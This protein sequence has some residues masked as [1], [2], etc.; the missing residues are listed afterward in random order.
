MPEL[1]FH[2]WE[3]IEQQQIDDDDDDEEQ[4]MDL[5]EDNLNQEQEQ[6]NRLQG[7]LIQSRL[8]F[9]YFKIYADIQLEQILNIQRH[10]LFDLNNRQ[11]NLDDMDDDDD[12]NWDDAEAGKIF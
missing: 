3:G 11:G 8:F 12:E 7:K 1:A 4:E 10:L 9:Q 5:L 2:P 6:L